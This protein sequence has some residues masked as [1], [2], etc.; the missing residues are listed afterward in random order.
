MNIDLSTTYLT[1]RLKNPLVVSAGPLTDRPTYWKDLEQAGAA[2]LVL[3]SLFEEQIEHDEWQSHQLQQF[4]SESFAEALDYFP[5]L[6]DHR[7]G[8][9]QYL[10]KIERAKAEV[11]IPVIASLNGVSPGGWSKYARLMQDAGADAIEL[12]IYSL[13][14]DP[15]LSGSAYEDRYIELVC[16]IKEQIR[17]PMAVKLGPFFSALPHMALRFEQAGASGLV[18]F[19]RLFHSDI[20]LTNLEFVQRLELSHPSENR[21]SVHWIALLREH[22]K[23]SLAAN[24]G[25]RTVEDIVKAILVGADATMLLAVLLENGPG[26]LRTLLDGL[27]AWLRANEYTSIDQMKGSMCRAHCPNPEALER[28]NYMRLLHSYSSPTY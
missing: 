23:L 19:N 10:H 26:H 9:S 14:T 27:S 11:R 21:L 22:L 16:Q 8:P 17:I 1:L 5:T 25:I 6:E 12:N 3:P 15:H 4:G 18:L 28:V 7:L 20:D 13:P 24:S 2:A